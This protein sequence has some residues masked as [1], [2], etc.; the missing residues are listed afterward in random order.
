MTVQNR[1]YSLLKKCVF[2]NGQLPERSRFIC[3]RNRLM[4]QIICYHL[5]HDKVQ[6][7]FTI[8]DNSPMPLCKSIRNFRAKVFTG[9]ASKGYSSTKKMFYYEFKGSFEAARDSVIIMAYT[10][11]KASFHD[12]KMAKTLVNQYSCRKILALADENYISR[13]LKAELL[14]IGI[15]F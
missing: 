11:T 15:W 12:I 14:K 5:I 8:I 1:F 7:E 3:N 9:Y 10:L 4:I 6:P 13:K 2:I